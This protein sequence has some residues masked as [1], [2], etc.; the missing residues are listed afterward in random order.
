MIT[1]NL[2]IACT[3]GN[4]TAFSNYIKH[5]LA[6]LECLNCGVIHQTLENWTPEMYIGFYAHEY[7]LDYQ[8]N[9]GTMTYEF[10]YEHDC[11]VSDTR[12]EAYKELLRPGSSGIDIGSSNSAFVHRAIDMG[13]KCVGL[14][15][16][17]HIGDD[18]VTIRG[19]LEDTELAANEYDWA[20]LHDSIEHMIDVNKAFEKLNLILKKGG[21][22]VLDLPD[23]FIPQGFH[24]WKRIEHLWLFSKDQFSEI[25]R[26]HGF[27]I[28]KITAPIPGKLV[29]YARKR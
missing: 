11:K 25:I 23:Y 14:E 15:P 12:L 21:L 5:D 26:S 18:S 4:E 9:R 3:C 7:H 28:E 27:S 10:R 17:E 1:N 6:V 29:F 2:I 20:T 16:G 19:T 24:H 13:Y 8:E 22:A